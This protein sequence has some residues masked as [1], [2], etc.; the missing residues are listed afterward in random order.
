MLLKG[1]LWYV[2]EIECNVQGSHK[3]VH[4]LI[5]IGKVEQ[6][7]HF[8]HKHKICGGF[9]APLNYVD[10]CII[11]ID[12]IFYVMFTTNHIVASVR[13]KNSYTSTL[14]NR[15]GGELHIQ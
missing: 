5:E 14:I 12:N 4:N 3:G 9:V 7:E 2:E 1:C 15:L 6:W 10:Y 13:K 8:Q 11:I